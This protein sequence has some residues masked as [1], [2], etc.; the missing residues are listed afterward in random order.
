MPIVAG[1]LLIKFSGTGGTP[2]TSLGGAIHATTITDNSLH[3]LFDVVSSGEALSGSTEYR[4]VYL[5]NNHGSL[6]LNDAYVYMTGATPGGSSAEIAAGSSAVN[7]TEQTIA[8]ETTAP[9]GVTWVSGVGSGNLVVLG[10]IPAGQHKAIWI[11][12]IIPAS[13][14]TYSNDSLVLQ[15][16]GATPA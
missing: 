16:G 14:G 13:T 4:C 1:D 10:N 3:N 8:N 15:V 12:R 2:A 7:G 9:T 6:T 5:K 11:K